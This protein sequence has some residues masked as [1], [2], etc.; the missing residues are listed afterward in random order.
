ML[1]E[2]IC[3][4]TVTYGNRRHLLTKVIDALE[5]EGIQ[6]VVV[7]DNGCEWDVSSWSRQFSNVNVDVLGLPENLGSAGGYGAGLRHALKRGY[8]L[9]WLLDDDN[10]PQCGALEILL[11]RYSRLLEMHDRSKLAVCSFRVKSQQY[12]LSKWQ[13]NP[14]GKFFRVNILDIPRRLFV[15]LAPRSFSERDDEAVALMHAPYGGLL[16]H[17][18]VVGRI[19]YPN[20]E[21]V[22]YSD[23]LEY[24][25]RL[26][27]SGGRI[28]LVRRSRVVDLESQ[29]HD[30]ESSGWGLF[31]VLTKGNDTTV[32]Y[33][34]RNQA[35]MDSRRGANSV[36]Y[37]VNRKIY[38]TLLW[39]MAKLRGQ[40]VR[41]HLIVQAIEDGEA[42]RLGRCDDYRV[43]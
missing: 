33:A 26:T 6:D 38:I 29:G 7:V 11:T 15:S 31:P 3:V 1:S 28:Q 23:D 5:K 19:G 13:E 39:A 22:V 25:E 40:M 37:K 30:K 24:T 4:V 32:Y 21:F 8:S 34:A 12:L 17:K 35:Y 16:L 27:E 41:Y 36:T 9:I 43:P 18:D 42:G 14:N 10:R 2:Q 20:P